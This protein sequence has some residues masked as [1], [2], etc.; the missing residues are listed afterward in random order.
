[1]FCYIFLFC[2]QRAVIEDD[3]NLITVLF[4]YSSNQMA[5]QGFT[6]CSTDCVRLIRFPDRWCLIT[7]VF[8]FC[9]LLAQ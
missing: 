3:D 9:W 1:M 2:V 5:M 7:P 8:I 6:M 4:G